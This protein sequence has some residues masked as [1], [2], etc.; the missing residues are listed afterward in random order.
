LHEEID[1]LYFGVAGGWG[2][3]VGLGVGL[4]KVNGIVGLGRSYPVVV[5]LII[6]NLHQ[7]VIQK[8]MFVSITLVASELQ[9]AWL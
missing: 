4:G 8:R 7:N 1:L 2:L 5:A 3:T 9:L 6:R